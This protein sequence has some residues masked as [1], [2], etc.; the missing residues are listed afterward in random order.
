MFTSINNGHT[1]ILHGHQRH[2]RKSSAS[3]TY[4]IFGQPQTTV[5][6]ELGALLKGTSDLFDAGC[7]RKPGNGRKEGHDGNFGNG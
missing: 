4:N 1:A 6:R 5:P 3:I 7:F 2:K